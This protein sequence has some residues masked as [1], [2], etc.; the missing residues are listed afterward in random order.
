MKS[1]LFTKQDYDKL[2]KLSP[3]E[4][5][6][7]LQ[8]HVYTDEINSL[9]IRY[10]GIELIQ[11]AL[12]MHLSKILN[13]LYRISDVDTREVL[14]AYIKKYDVYNYKTMLRG[15]ATNTSF[16]KI[17]NMLI[18]INTTYDELETLYSR[19][20]EDILKK[21]PKS[22]LDIEKLYDIENILDNDYFTQLINIQSELDNVELG[23]Y[24]DYLIDVHNLK[25]V[26]KAQKFKLSKESVTEFLILKGG[27]IK[28]DLFDKLLDTT[29]FEELFILLK[30]T[31]YFKIINRDTISSDEIVLDSYLLNQSKKLFHKKPLSNDVVF[32]YVFSK[33]IEIQNIMII[34]K[35]KLLSVDEKLVESI[36]LR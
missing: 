4:I 23:K 18:P 34:A 33:E 12:Y 30:N 24:I 13:K 10:S 17:K 6:K 16:E 22:C 36:I 20:K 8:D 21:L 25:L 26:I 15:K 35:S 28:K 14:G 2:L 27:T 11:I 29:S 1:L 3:L 5:S 9:A 31:R 7:Y 32:S 19:S